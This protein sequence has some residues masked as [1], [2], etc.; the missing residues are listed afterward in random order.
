MEAQYTLFSLY[1][2]TGVQDLNLRDG[3]SDVLGGPISKEAAFVGDSGADS[4]NI[5]A[6]V[7]TCSIMITIIIPYRVLYHSYTSYIKVPESLFS[8]LRPLGVTVCVYITPCLPWG[9]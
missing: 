8:S 6:S 7:I 3:G 9:N 4:R 5:E 2:A 1:S